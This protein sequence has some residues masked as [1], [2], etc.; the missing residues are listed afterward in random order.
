MKNK[1]IVKVISIFMLAALLLSTFALPVFATVDGEEA[2][3]TFWDQLV[4]AIFYIVELVITAFLVVCYLIIGIVVVI[5]L[6]FIGALRLLFELGGA[7]VDLIMLIVN[8][9]IGLF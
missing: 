5:A 4:D 3:L 9:I 6:L 7:M 8:G 2:D 1:K